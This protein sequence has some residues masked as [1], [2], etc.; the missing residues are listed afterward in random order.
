MRILKLSKALFLNDVREFS[1]FFWPFV[2]PTD[3][4]FSLLVSVFLWVIA[5]PMVELFSGS[6]S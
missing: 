4:V 5:L 3:F 1:G 2:F 6:G